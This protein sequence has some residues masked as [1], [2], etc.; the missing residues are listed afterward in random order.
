VL[1]VIVVLDHY[2]VLVQHG[3]YFTLYSNLEQVFVKRD[4]KVV[5][6]QPIG[7]V[8]TNEDDGKTEIHL[9]IW[10][11]GNKM[12]PEAWIAAK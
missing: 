10:R 11:G 7:I 2:A 5:T 1:Q 9:E 8:Q 12:D 6:K 3:E 4:D